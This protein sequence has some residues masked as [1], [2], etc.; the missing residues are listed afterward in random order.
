MKLGFY[1]NFSKQI[2]RFARE[3]GFQSLELSAWPE[4]SLNADH[5][6]DRE[7]ADICRDLE[8]NGLEISALGYYP[9]FQHPDPAIRTETRRYF[10]RVLDLAQRMNVRDV[11]T[12]AGQVPGISIEDNLPSVKELFTYFCDEAEKRNLRIAIENCPMLD[13]KTLQ[14]ENIAISPEVWDAMFEE[15]PSSALG[16]E[17]DPSH[18]VWQGIDYV[19]AIHDY[20]SRI[21]HV[22]AKDMEIRRDILARV[23]IYG[24][25]FGE[26]KDFG[27][28]WWRPRTPGWGEVDWPRFIT[29]LIEVNYPGNIDIEH[30]DH[31]FAQLSNV[32]QVVQESDIVASYGTEEKGLVLGYRTLSRLLV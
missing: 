9:N 15:V 3:V 21:Y 16:L 25:A 32:G 23:G 12:F 4:S 5:I 27:A 7:L 29:A 31:V 28:G 13:R 1:T 20:G 2:V 8:T 22:H 26:V 6:S 24:Q 10:V 11:A 17:F 19:K 18:L 30:E 14:G